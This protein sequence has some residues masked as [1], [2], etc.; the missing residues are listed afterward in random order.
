MDMT[1]DIFADQVF[2]KIALRK[3]SPVPE[4]FRLYMAGWLGDKPSK[5]GVM[6]VAGAQFRVA[7]SGK[8]KGKLSIMI[9]GTKRTAYVTADE[10]HIEEC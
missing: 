6:E 3:L 2:G 5:T 9:P 10:M 1:H 8:N 7:K 4:N